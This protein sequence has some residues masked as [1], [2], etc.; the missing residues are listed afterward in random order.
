MA[1]VVKRKNTWF[2]HWTGLDGQRVMKSTKVK[3]KVPG[4]TEKQTRALAKNVADAMESAAKGTSLVDKALEAIRGVAEVNGF[5]KPVP[6]IEDYLKGFPAQASEKS[7]QQRQRT[8][9]SFIEWLGKDAKLPITRI[10]PE[11]VKGHLVWLLEN[12]RLGT[13][14]RHRQNLACA[15]NKAVDVDQILVHSPMKAVKLGQIMKSIGAEDDS[16][17][18]LPFSVEEMQTILNRFPQPYSDLAAASFYTGGLR[19]G[20]VCMLRWSDVDLEKGTIAVKEQKTGKPRLIHLL[21]ALRE[22]LL[23]RK[24]QEEGEEYVFPETA[25]KYEYSQCTISTD[26][27]SLLNAFG[28]KTREESQTPLKGKRRPVTL[29]CFHS[30]RH[31]VVSWARSNPNLSASVVRET[32]GHSSDDIE[33]RYYFTAEDKAKLAVLEAV[34]DMVSPDSAA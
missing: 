14:V 12:Y 28:I 23:A 33:M 9:R 26:F 15:F 11:H 34:A 10:T 24:A 8:F 13:V 21:P 29:K 4:Q 1:G 19:L 6:T 16:V 22:R 3:V 18:R 20:D 27:T 17:S 31:S 32:V 30:I 7:E 5:A 25:R 2:A